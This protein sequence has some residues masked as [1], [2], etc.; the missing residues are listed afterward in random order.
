MGKKTIRDYDLL[1]LHIGFMEDKE[2][3]YRKIIEEKSIQ[4]LHEDYDAE[5]KL[6]LKQEVVFTIIMEMINSG[7]NDA[8]FIDELG[9]IGKIFFY[10]TLLAQVRSRRLIALATITSGVAAV[11]LLGG[12]ITH[13]QF[14][15]PLNLNDT[16]FCDF[17]K[18]EGPQ[19]YYKRHP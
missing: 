9:G 19:S 18:Q 5:I 10:R 17:S 3:N 13:S 16:N 14:V 12:R 1:F 6:N 15:L 2:A 8:F 7:R 11:I 4:V